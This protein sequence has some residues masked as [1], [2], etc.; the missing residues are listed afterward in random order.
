MIPWRIWDTIDICQ[1]RIRLIRRIDPD[2]FLSVLRMPSTH[3]V[4]TTVICGRFEKNV[5]LYGSVNILWFQLSVINI[6][7]TAIRGSIHTRQFI[8]IFKIRCV[9]AVIVVWR[10]RHKTA[11]KY[12]KPEKVHAIYPRIFWS[13]T[14]KILK[15]C[16]P[17]HFC[18]SHR[19]GD[20]NG[21]IKRYKQI[22]LSAINRTILW[23]KPLPNL[24]QSL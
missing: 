4:S 12:S 24:A 16:N 13:A 22:K 6:V 8:V 15:H 2:V 21:T 14:I 7:I 20:C 10:W 17:R 9:I 23:P 5:L 18:V 3:K 11:D 1:I 19:K